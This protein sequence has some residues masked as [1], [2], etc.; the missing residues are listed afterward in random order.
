MKIKNLKYILLLFLLCIFSYWLVIWADD[1]PNQDSCPSGLPEHSSNNGPNYVNT[2]NWYYNNSQWL[3]WW[4]TANP[5]SNYE[6]RNIT[7]LINYKANLLQEYDSSLWLDF[8]N[9]NNIWHLQNA[10]R[11]AQWPGCNSSLPRDCRLWRDT[12]SAFFNCN[13]CKGINDSY[14]EWSAWPGQC[15]DE[16]ELE[17]WCCKP[18][19]VIT[20][21]FWQENWNWNVLTLDVLFTATNATISDDNFDCDI[22]SFNIEWANF[23]DVSPEIIEEPVEMVSCELIINGSAQII[24]VTVSEWVVQIWNK[25]SP[26]ATQT[27]TM[28]EDCWSTPKS[29]DTPCT[30][31]YGP[32]YTESGT[33]CVTQCAIP[34]KTW[35]GCNTWYIKDGSGCCVQNNCQNPPLTWTQ[36]CSNQFWWRWVYSGAIECCV[37]SGSCANPPASPWQCSWNLVLDSA[38]QCCIT[39]QNPVNSSGNC[40]SW[41]TAQWNCCFANNMCWNTWYNE[42]WQCHQCEEWTV[43]NAEGTKCVCDPNKKCCWIQLNTVVPFIWDCIEMTASSRWDTTSVTSVTAFPVLMQWLMKILMSAIMIFSFLMVIIAWFMMTTW[44]FSSWNFAKWKT[45]LKNVIISLILLGCSWL[46]LSLI[47]P[48]FFGG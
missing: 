2:S 30:T 33:C 19:P 15:P 41:Y 38:G 32:S 39:C 22:W 17:W 7:N 46:I 44:A 14:V 5:I 47:N 42:W 40:Q 36:D 28:P 21:Q 48:N 35:W 8:S 20:T 11:L 26:E 10:I 6:S 3:I 4:Y 18:E 27:F 45:I 29:G 13:A 12:S 1:I 43:A 9:P 24:T 23:Y 25:N 34:Q 16:F 31:T 37:D